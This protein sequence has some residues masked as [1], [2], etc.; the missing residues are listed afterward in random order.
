MLKKISAWTFYPTFLLVSFITIIESANAGTNNKYASIVMDYDS[1]VILHQ[2]YADKI[3][4]PASLTKVMTLVLLFDELDSRRL[5]MGT[6]I[7]MTENAASMIPSK[8][9]LK[10]GERIKVKDAI[11]S[12]VTKS[13]ND[14]AVAIAEHIAGSE[15]RFSRLMNIKAKQIG[16]KDTFFVNASGLHN[17]RQVS[18]ARDM[19]LLAKYVISEYPHYY[20][21]FSRKGFTYKGEYYKNHNALLGTYKGM[22]GLKTGYISRSGFNLMASAKRKGRRVIGVVFGGRS[23]ATRNAHMVELLD[24]AFEKLDDVYLVASKV[25]MPA[26]KPYF[27]AKIKHHHTNTE[28]ASLNNIETASGRKPTYRKISINP[29]SLTGA[30]TEKIWQNLSQRN[31][32]VKTT[33]SNNSYKK[34]AHNDNAMIVPVNDNR[35][36]ESSSQNNS[37]SIQI[38]AFSSRVTTDMVLEKSLQNLPHNLSH[39]KPVITPVRQGNDFLFRAHLSGFTEQDANQA[40]RYFDECITVPPKTLMN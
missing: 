8:L 14:V 18:T 28:T 21:F 12:L 16:M 3:L 15:A 38:G 32:V 24:R 36:I 19:A 1:G 26:K 29:T 13:A 10:T 37:W 6:N 11:Y 33:S 4:H 2:R 31:Q 20:H 17:P 39:A 5:Y 25:P 22:D 7:T 23:S 9:D 30:V 35:H 27:Y 40:C 34:L